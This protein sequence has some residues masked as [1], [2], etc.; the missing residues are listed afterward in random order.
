MTYTDDKA[1]YLRST[2]WDTLLNSSILHAH[3]LQTDA[4]TSELMWRTLCLHLHVPAG[5][6]RF[7]GAH[8][9]IVG[10]IFAEVKVTSSSVEHCMRC[11]G[12]ALIVSGH[13]LDLAQGRSAFLQVRVNIRSLSARKSI[14]QDPT[15]TP[16]NLL[17][18]EVLMWL[19]G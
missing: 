3:S 10:G 19:Q 12:V 11:S 7:V 1:M 8:R 4:A 16:P 5:C 2:V 14:N 9:D 13:R 15:W 18:L 6:S 17:G